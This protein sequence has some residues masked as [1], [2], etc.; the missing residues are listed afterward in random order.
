[1]RGGVSAPF[2]EEGKVRVCKH[3]Q[4]KVELLNRALL[5][6][7]EGG[8]ARRWRCVADIRH[9][10]VARLKTVEMLEAPDKERSIQARQVRSTVLSSISFTRAPRL[11]ST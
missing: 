2:V 3:F 4:L 1:M 10:Q 9:R 8:G 11:G 7:I 5:R 6:H